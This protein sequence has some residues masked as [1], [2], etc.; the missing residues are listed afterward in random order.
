[1][2]HIS[3]ESLVRLILESDRESRN[4]DLRLYTRVIMHD[5]YEDLGWLTAK[6]V[7]D[8]ILKKETRD[9]EDVVRI[10]RELLNDQGS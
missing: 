5:L 9:F 10:K 1:M 7:L 8:M 2:K 4:C 3:T 6:D